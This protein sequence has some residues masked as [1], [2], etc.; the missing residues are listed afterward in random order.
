MATNPVP[1]FPDGFLWG[2]S[3]SAHQTEG[4]AELRG[5]SVWDVFTSG[6]GAGEGRLDGGGGLRPLPPLPRGRGAAGGPGR[7]RVP[8]L[9]LLASG[10]LPRRPRPPTDR[11]VDELCAAGVRPVPTLFHW[12]LPA[13]LDWLERGHGVAFRPVRVGGRG[14]ARR[15]RRQ[16]DHS[17]RARRAHPAGPR[18]RRA[19]PRPEAAVRTPCRWPTTSC[20][21]TASRYGPC[22]SG[23]A[24]IGIANSHGPTWPASDEAADRE[25]ADFYDV[26]LEPDVRR[27]RADRGGTRTASRS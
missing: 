13:G 9:G 2:V 18:P 6:A 14:P 16:V 27:P 20:S 3:T 5:P 22:A 21:C 11:L 15:P 8:L 19:R 4:A 7:G 1:R 24:D 10:G 23:A 12:D 26:L 25:A 17:E